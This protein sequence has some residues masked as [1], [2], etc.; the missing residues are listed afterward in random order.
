M[1]EKEFP[2]GKLLSHAIEKARREE[3]LIF[4]YFYRRS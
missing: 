2:W 1:K 3:K 4:A